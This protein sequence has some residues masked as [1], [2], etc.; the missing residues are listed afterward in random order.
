MMISC[1]I[2]I[3]DNDIDLARVGDKILKISKIQSQFP[4]NISEQDSLMLLNRLINDWAVNELIYQNAQLNISQVEKDKLKKISENYY[5]TLLIDKYKTKISRNNV[6]TIVTLDELKSFYNENIKNLILNEEIVE[7]RYIKLNSGSFNL[8]EIKR[9]FKRFNIADKIFFDSISIQ[10]LNYY[11]DDSTWINKNLFF[12]KIPALKKEEI[13]KISKNK[14]FYISEDSLALYLIKIKS[15]KGV[16]ENAPFEY[17]YTRIES[18]LK[19]KKKLNFLKNI[20]L[21]I[22]SDGTKQGLFEIY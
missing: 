3:V 7:G 15:Y 22:I 10:L 20:D 9:R 17:I 21:E 6:D 14:L 4:K 12:S 5:K 8:R 19:N 1:D 2:E 18:I 13:D 11:L 16:D